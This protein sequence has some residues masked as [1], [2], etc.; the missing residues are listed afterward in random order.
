MKDESRAI[1]AY[2]A[3]MP[4]V[5]AGRGCLRFRDRQRLPLADLA[6]V[7]RNALAP[8]RALLAREIAKRRR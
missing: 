4:E 6:Q 1:V 3:G 7:V 8:G 2:L 5:S